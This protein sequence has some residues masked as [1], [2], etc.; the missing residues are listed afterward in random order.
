MN[1]LTFIQESTNFQFLSVCHYI[2]SLGIIFSNLNLISLDERNNSIIILNT[3]FQYL[4]NSIENDESMLK[5]ELLRRILKGSDLYGG[6]KNETLDM[7]Y[8]D[9]TYQYI[10]NTALFSHYGNINGYLAGI[11]N[12]RDNILYSLFKKNVFQHFS[13][14]YTSQDYCWTRNENIKLTSLTIEKVFNDY[15]WSIFPPPEDNNMEIIDL[16]YI[17]AMIGLKIVRSINGDIKNQTFQ[18]Y[19]LISRAI[20]FQIFTNETKQLALELFSMPALFYY[21]YKF[22]VEF[23]NFNLNFSNEFWF[24]VYENFFFFLNIQIQKSINGEIKKSLHYKFQKKFEKLKSRTYIAAEIIYLI[25]DYSNIAQ[26]SPIYIYIYKTAQWLLKYIL[27]DNCRDIPDL[28]EY[29]NLQFSDIVKIY[30]EIEQNSLEQVLKDGNLIEKM[31]I[32]TTVEL[33]IVPDYPMYYTTIPPTPRKVN[34]DIY[35]IFAIKNNKPDYY[36]IK[37]ENNS[38]TLLKS[39]NNEQEFAKAIAN[40]STLKMQLHSFAPN[41]K[42]S[43]ENYKGFIKRIADIKTKQFKN[44][45]VNYYNEPTD[46]EKIFDFLKSLVPFYTCIQSIRINN[47]AQ[48][49]LSCSI[50][51]MSFLPMAGVGT[52]YSSIL[53]SSLTA[54]MITR[55]FLS[56]SRQIIKLPITTGLF[57]IY[58]SVMQTFG[59]NFFIKNFFKDLTIASLRTLDPGFEL[60][61]QVSKFSYRLLGKLFHSLPLRMKIIPEIKNLLSISK[62]INKNLLPYMELSSKIV[63]EDNFKIIR[64][65]YPGGLNYFGPTCIS[66]FGKIAEL[67][68]IEGNPFQVPVIPIREIDKIS[69]REYNPKT[70]KI[71]DDKLEMQNDILRRIIPYLNLDSNV[72]ITRN[73]I[74]NYNTVHWKKK[75]LHNLEGE[76]LNHGEINQGEILRGNPIVEEINHREILRGDSNNDPIINS[77]SENISK[78]DETSV[79]KDNKRVELEKIDFIPEKKIKLESKLS[80]NDLDNIPGTSKQINTNLN[81]YLSDNVPKFHNNFVTSLMVFKKKGL[82]VF[83]INEKINKFF[84]LSVTKLAFLQINRISYLPKPIELWCKKIVINRPKLITYLKKQKGST[85]FF[86]DITLL[87]DKEPIQSTNKINQFSHEIE[88]WYR[89]K[90]DSEYGIVY[91]SELDK[92]FQGDFITFSDVFFKVTDTYFLN[93][94]NN[95]LIIEMKSKTLTRENWLTNRNNNLLQLTQLKDNYSSRMKIIEN[96][97]NIMVENVPLCTYH[98]AEEILTSYILKLQSSSTLVPTY[99]QF[100][101]D[102][103][104]NMDILEFYQ[105]FKIKNWKYID[106]L[107]YERNLDKIENLNEATRRID[108]IYDLY[109]EQPVDIVFDK[110]KKLINY[111]E[112]IR[113][114]DYYVIYSHSHNML[115]YNK[116]NNRRYTAA[117]YRMAL[118][119]CNENWISESIKIYLGE[120]LTDDAYKIEAK[121]KIKE[122]ITFL[123][124]K[125][126]SKNREME[127]DIIKSRAI[128]S[129]QKLLLYEIEIKNQ[130]GIMNINQILENVNRNHFVMPKLKF[131][132]D[133]VKLDGIHQDVLLLKMHDFEIPTENRMVDIANDLDKLYA[134]TTEYYFTE[135]RN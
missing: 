44:G 107:L 3:F 81:W 130:A 65:I 127:L 115:T 124:I 25:C 77:D 110:Y 17:Y 56:V 87:N 85:F 58:K 90:F 2:N 49:A 32:N 134:T 7:K 11:I 112:Q 105:N 84:H 133:D 95:I 101:K 108:I 43:N 135:K 71:S 42:N 37:Q 21:A 88:I 35:L 73:Y 120:I 67:R 38:L 97:A 131:V 40:D 1:N 24:E 129:K 96:A 4:N 80:I 79:R 92:Q 19:I 31:D 29:Y 93:N 125:Q 68:T 50:D 102:Y 113:F 6:E 111:Q 13:Q 10:I 64:Y 69:Y 100:A 9:E 45:L 75:V 109:Y 20:E 104:N 128:T 132:I 103:Y 91:L 106:D 12:R 52:K 83:K 82:S 61:Y 63:K 14:N 116:N 72:K 122:H 15:I 22:K 59:K 54:E 76:N 41:L 46:I 51:I 5:L 123:E 114:E 47:K 23:Q 117:I 39:N 33:A 89:I 66:S 60:I 121:R 18:S 30:N 74:V 126:F 26:V 8:V 57:H 94:K 36:A 48:A 99:E 27:P 119:Q 55:E 28:E 78:N 62:N 34:S 16:N 70:D 118:K 98:I 86:N 53:W